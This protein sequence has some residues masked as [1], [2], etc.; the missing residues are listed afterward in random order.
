M[1][2]LSLMMMIGCVDPPT[3]DSGECGAAI[4]VESA[5]IGTEFSG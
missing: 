2:V 4:N 1:V 5:V 3:C